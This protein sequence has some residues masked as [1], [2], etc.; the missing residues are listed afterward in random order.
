MSQPANTQIYVLTQQE[1]G[2]IATELKYTATES[3]VVKGVYVVTNRAAG[4]SRS[5]VLTKQVARGG[6]KRS[7]VL[8]ERGCDPAARRS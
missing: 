2:D 7:Y 3:W 4:L 5:F 8:A 1:A 6:K